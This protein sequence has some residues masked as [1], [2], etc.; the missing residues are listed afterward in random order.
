MYFIIIYK[1]FN[2]NLLKTYSLNLT[3]LNHFI[4]LDF[5]SSLESEHGNCHL[6]RR[7]TLLNNKSWTHRDAAKRYAQIK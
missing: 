1:I 3:E 7:L 6:I 5:L 2:S 4:L